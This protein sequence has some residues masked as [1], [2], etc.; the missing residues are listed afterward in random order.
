MESEGVGMM[1]TVRTVLAG[2]FA[3]VIATCTVAGE[4]PKEK[5]KGPRLTPTARTMLRIERF[6]AA[7]HELEFTDEQGQKL[8]K[9]RDEFEPKLKEIH[10]KI[11]AILTEEQ[12]SAG[13]AAMK[14]AKDSGKT[15]KDRAYYEAIEAAVKLTDAQK[16]QL[17]KIDPDLRALFKEAS[18]KVMDVLTP[19]QQAKLK[20]KLPQP[21]KK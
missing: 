15:E 16:E 5:G 7:V 1:R 9:I 13:E 4:Q 21:K 10:G 19:E 3:L 8:E 12:K 11:A 2:A 17:T 20:E 14:S 18:K 6:R